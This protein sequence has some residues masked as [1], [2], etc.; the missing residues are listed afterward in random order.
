MKPSFLLLCLGFVC[1]MPIVAQSQEERKVVRC[2][3]TTT[4]LVKMSP[5]QR[6]R[7]AQ[8]PD[9]L[10]LEELNQCKEINTV[11]V[12]NSLSDAVVPNAL[13]VVAWNIERGRHWREAAE[14][15]QAHPVWK[16]ADVLLISEMDLGMSR[17]GNVHTTRE[18]AQALGMNYAYGVE[19][20]ELW[21]GGKRRDGANAE[22]DYGYHGNAILSRYPLQNVRMLRFPGIERWYGTSQ[23][24]LG[25]RNAILAEIKTQN[26]NISLVSTH[27]E[28]GFGDNAL[29]V[30][31]IQMILEELDAY[32][33]N[34]AVIL[35]G[36]LNAVPGSEP[37][38]ML[39]AA[40]FELDASNLLKEG[41]SQGLKKDGSVGRFMHIDY[42]AVRGLK[43]HSPEVLDA[44]HKRNDNVALISD[45]AAVAVVVVLRNELP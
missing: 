19:Y 40:G 14:L 8:N 29:R 32:N 18:L 5:E 21:E 37:I 31:E 10:P 13:H 12:D 26:G 22:Q 41:T 24:R 4:A 15:L 35:G 20:L 43:A 11:E 6:T 36:D 27:L 39:R 23:H 9:Q 17:S 33:P 38:T 34:Q 25:G 44:V 28:S 1:C 3:E 7:L 2:T 30:E 45:H 16:H 42:I